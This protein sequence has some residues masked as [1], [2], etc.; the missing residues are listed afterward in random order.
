MENQNVDNGHTEPERELEPL[1][2][3]SQVAQYL[4]VKPITV[5]RWL[6]EKRVIEPKKV[7]R[8]SNRVRIPRSEVLRIAGSIKR[9]LQGQ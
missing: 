2:T 9:K 6:S 7:V 8:I 5:Y 4:S 3:V 1:W